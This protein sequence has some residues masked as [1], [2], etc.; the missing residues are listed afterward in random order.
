MWRLLLFLDL[1][2]CEGNV[3]TGEEIEDEGVEVVGRKRS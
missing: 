3:R 1:P 2:S